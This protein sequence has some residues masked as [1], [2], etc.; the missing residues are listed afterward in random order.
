MTRKSSSIVVTCLCLIVAL[1][2]VAADAK[3]QPKAMPDFQSTIVSELTEAEKKVVA[4]AEAM[5]QEK[6]GWRPADGV[7]SVAEAFMHIGQ[8]NY[9][10]SAFARTAPPTPSAKFTVWSYHAIGAGATAFSLV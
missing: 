8:A 3:P 7:R 10:A 1:P 5:P 6:Y 9:L 2:L 4:L